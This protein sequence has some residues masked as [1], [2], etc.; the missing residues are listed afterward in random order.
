MYIIYGVSS[1]LNSMRGGLQ[2]DI[3][4]NVTVIHFVN[5]DSEAY[6][7]TNNVKLKT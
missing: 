7:I 5:Q 4:E 1:T 6:P 2:F 3:L